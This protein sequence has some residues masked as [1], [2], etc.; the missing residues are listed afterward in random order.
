MAPAL[1]SLLFRLI[2]A[3]QL[4][5]ALTASAADVTGYVV[6]TSDYVFRG[7]TYS[8]GNPAAQIGG[9]VSFNNGIFLGAWGST[10]DISNGPQVQRDWEVNYY[11]GYNRDLSSHWAIGATFVAYRFPGTVGRFDYDY[12]EF[13]INVNYDD[14]IWFEYAY[15]PDL[16]DSGYSTGNFLLFGE[17]PLGNSFTG[18]AGAGYYDVSNFSG[19][20]Y[21]YWEIGVTRPFGVIDF[22]L[23]YHDTSNSVRIISTPDRADS[24]AVISARFQF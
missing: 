5:F 9:D 16:Y 1:K 21:T 10:I 13:A 8:D 6:L 24:R 18:S 17:L 14:R 23:R 11:I 12:E 4:L 20:D 19:D 15:S 22:D 2:A 7:V 3:S